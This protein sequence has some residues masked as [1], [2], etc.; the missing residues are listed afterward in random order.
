M[1]L[2]SGYEKLESELVNINNELLKVHSSLHDLQKRQE[3]NKA[4]RED[5]LQFM[6]KAD[7]IISQAESGKVKLSE[8]Q[9]T[10]IRETLKKIQVIFKT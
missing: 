1:E 2:E 5:A 6:E 9:I 7:K 4:L 10:R 3:V 8:E